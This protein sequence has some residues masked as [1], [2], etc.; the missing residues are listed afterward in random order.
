MQTIGL[1]HVFEKYHNFTP[2]DFAVVRNDVGLTKQLI[3]LGANIHGNAD[4]PLR[5][6]CKLGHLEIVQCLIEAGANIHAV[7]EKGNAPLHYA[8]VKSFTAIIDDLESKM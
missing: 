7:D 4:Q 6:A 3:K 5:N 8:R 1:E 2:I